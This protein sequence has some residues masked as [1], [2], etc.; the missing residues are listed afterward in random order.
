V[1]A[2]KDAQ[3]GYAQAEQDQPTSPLKSVI[4]F[5]ETEGRRRVTGTRRCGRIRAGPN[6]TI[7]PTPAFGFFWRSAI[8]TFGDDL[9]TA[10]Y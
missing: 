9:L 5:F 4:G 3:L 10:A 2:L 7:S 6:P 1:L 8:Y